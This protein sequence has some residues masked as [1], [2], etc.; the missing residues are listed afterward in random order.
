MKRFPWL[1]LSVSVLAL[2]LWVALPGCGGSGGN[3]GGGGGQQQGGQSEQGD[4][5][6]HD[7][8][9][10]Q[11]HDHGDHAHHDHEHDSEEIAANLAKL[12]AE[13]RKLAEKQK[14][15]PVTDEPLGSM[16][17]PKKVSVKGQ[18]VFICC[19]GCEEK[20]TA[21]PDKYLAKLKK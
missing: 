1:S 10:H 12:S 17:V 8:G 7:H 5:Q 4:H 20:L 6:G 9:D 18:D 14:V 13:D 16:G 3:S 11:G 2:A 15:C 21:D 19:E